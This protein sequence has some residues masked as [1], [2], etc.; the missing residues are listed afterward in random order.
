MTLRKIASLNK[1]LI[2]E[3]FDKNTFQKGWD[4]FQHDY[5]ENI[6]LLGG[7]LYGNVASHRKLYHVEVDLASLQNKCSC[8]IGKNC[9]HA[10]GLLS[11]AVQGKRFVDGNTLIQ[12]MNQMSKSTLLKFITQLMVKQPSV[13][14]SIAKLIPISPLQSQR[15]PSPLR[16]QR[17]KNEMHELL[18]DLME[19][20]LDPKTWV[21]QFV[22]F[23]KNN[24]SSFKKELVYDAMN[25]LISY[26][27]EYGGFYVYYTDSSYDE[28]VFEVLADVWLQCGISEEDIDKL[29]EFDKSYPYGFIN[30]FIKGIISPSNAPLLVEFTENLY[31]LFH[32]Y[33]QYIEFLINSGQ[34]DEA[35]KEILK[36]GYTLTNIKKFDYLGKIDETL[37]IN[38][39]QEK[40]LDVQLIEY[41]QVQNKLDKALSL[42]K[43]A[44]TSKTRTRKLSQRQ[45]TS[46]YLFHIIQDQPS[47]AEEERRD[48]LRDLFEV[49]HV[50]QHYE[51]KARIALEY[52]EEL[53]LIRMVPIPKALWEENFALGFEILK[54]LKKDH[55][56]KVTRELRKLFKWTI[57]SDVL[58]SEH[59]QKTLLELRSMEPQAKWSNFVEN[60][61]EKYYRKRIWLDLRSRGINIRK[62][63]GKVTIV[64]ET[65]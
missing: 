39:A 50:G 17:L 58:T 41:Y 4:Y 9:K 30:S 18:N 61:Y 38:F 25:F 46:K 13:A 65:K 28:P 47:L 44:I 57:T 6:L 5:V 8:P 53:L 19:L 11:V 20:K 54:V 45:K 55:P 29:K 48:L 35:I 2:R 22:F 43:E 14:I 3:Y 36:R 16:V 33:N 49:A 62:I 64:I 23:I 51:I 31:S 1:D 21:D 56:K 15:A 63:K 59:A 32:R 27:D 37:A 12:Q 7:M 52:K 60:V 34:T 40:R 24:Q 26:M 42:F 10:V